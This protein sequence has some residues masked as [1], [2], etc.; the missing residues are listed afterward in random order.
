MSRI[1][2][3]NFRHPDG[4]SDN[5]NLT[6]T[7]RVGIGTA[8]PTQLLEISGASTPGVQIRDT[9]NQVIA[10]LGADD[11]VAKVGSRS[12]HPLQFQVNDAE[13]ARL[14]TSGHF[15]F[16][17]GYG[18]VAT[19]Y[20]CRAWANFQGTGTVSIRGD[21][22]VSSITDN[23]TGDYTVNFTT[24]MPDTTYAVVDS[25]AQLGGGV[26]ANDNGVSF[27][28]HTYSS[29]SIRGLTSY[30]DVKVD[31]QFVNVAIFR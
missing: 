27:Q 20:G 28:P 19:A 24:A 3:A 18:D 10:R 7:G 31:T 6:D 11:Y 21:G 2:V 26:G 15:Q 9:T 5:I 14:D 13:V 30:T 4:T 8:A 16:N 22:N 23:G 12:N 25:C 17:S 1:N 29:G